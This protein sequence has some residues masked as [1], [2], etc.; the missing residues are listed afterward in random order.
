MTQQAKEI[1][2][3]WQADVLNIVITQTKYLDISFWE[4][5]IREMPNKQ[6]TK[7][8]TIRAI[9]DCTEAIDNHAKEHLKNIKE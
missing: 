9:I 2:M 7:A 8:K 5:F 1:Y 6:S 4:A 3:N